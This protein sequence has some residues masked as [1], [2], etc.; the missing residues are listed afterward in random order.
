LNTASSAI[1][2]VVFGFSFQRSS[3]SMIPAAYSALLR[4]IPRVQS[5]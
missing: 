4:Y 5:R 2:F 1:T 3:H